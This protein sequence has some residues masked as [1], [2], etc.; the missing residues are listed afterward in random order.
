ME[1]VKKT[2]VSREDYLK[3]ELDCLERKRLIIIAASIHAAEVMISQSLRL[4]SA[5]MVLL[6]DS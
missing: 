2:K 4:N 6:M 3:M 5:K 1:K